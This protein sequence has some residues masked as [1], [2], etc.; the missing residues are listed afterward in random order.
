MDDERTKSRRRLITKAYLLYGDVRPCHSVGTWERCFTEQGDDLLLWFD[1]SDGSTHLI[2]ESPRR[3]HTKPPSE[4][5]T[6][7]S[8]EERS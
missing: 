1:T 8:A 5:E 6:D 7:Q 4:N 2:R 3:R